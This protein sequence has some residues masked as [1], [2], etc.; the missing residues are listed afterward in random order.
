MRC[1]CPAGPSEKSS[2]YGVAFAPLAWAPFPNLKFFSLNVAGDRVLV[3]R[4]RRLPRLLGLEPALGLRAPGVEKGWFGE[5]PNHTNYSDQSSVRI[6]FK[7]DSRIL[8]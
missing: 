7:N 2:K 3:L 6:L 8:R 4:Q 1:L 5:G